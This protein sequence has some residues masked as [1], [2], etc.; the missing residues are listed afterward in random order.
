L[1]GGTIRIRSTLGNGTIVQ[2]HLP[3]DK[4]VCA[5]AAK[6]AAARRPLTSVQPHLAGRGGVTRP[7]VQLSRRPH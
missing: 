1:H 3:I 4:P 5:V 7:E 6:P 2:V